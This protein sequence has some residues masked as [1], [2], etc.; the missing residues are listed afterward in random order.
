M[1]HP[2]AGRCR[3]NAASTS[4]RC[5]HQGMKRPRSGARGRRGVGEEEHAVG[6]DLVAADGLP[7]DVPAAAEEPAVDARL[8]ESRR[9]PARRTATRP[10][11][12]RARPR[13][14]GACGPRAGG[15]RCPGPAGRSPPASRGAHRRGPANSATATPPAAAASWPTGIL[16]CCWAWNGFRQSSES[17]R[18]HVRPAVVPRRLTGMPIC[19]AREALLSQISSQWSPTIRAL[20]GMPVCSALEALLGQISSQWLPTIRAR[21]RLR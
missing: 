7:G 13:R 16:A 4:S 14:P 2:P 15:P 12:R 19:S 11:P 17:I 5:E 8:A 3:R 20:T 6:A 10:R 9:S 21:L 18:W 1:C